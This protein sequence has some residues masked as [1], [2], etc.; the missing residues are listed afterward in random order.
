MGPDISNIFDGP[1]WCHDV[2]RDTIDPRNE[3]KEAILALLMAARAQ[4]TVMVY[5]LLP[6][7][8][9]GADLLVYLP[10]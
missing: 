2:S 7:S 5:F 3:N 6:S 8:Y 10:M 9:M 4:S 1:S